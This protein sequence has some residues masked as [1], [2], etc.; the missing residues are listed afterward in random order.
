MTYCVEPFI[1]DLVWCWLDSHSDYTAVAGEVGIGSGVNSGRIDLV[2]KTTEGEFHGF[3]I[4]NNA[5][6]DEQLN[7]YLQSGYLDRLYHCSRVGTTFA[8]R[9]HDG[10]KVKNTTYNNQQIR[11][12]I[13][14]GIAVGQYTEEEYKQALRETF[15]EEILDQQAGIASQVN[16]RVLDESEKTVWARLTRNIGIPTADFDPSETYISLEKAM[17]MMWNNQAVPTEIGLIDVPFSYDLSEEDDGFRRQLNESVEVMF[18]KEKQ[19]KVEVV[20]QAE[21]LHREQSLTLSQ[22]NEAWVQHYAWISH[23]TIREAV[24]PYVAD[25]AE[26]LIDIMGFEGA[27][28]PTE[29]Y[30]AGE[31]AQLLGIEAKGDAAFGGKE[32]IESIREQL[33]KYQTSGVLTHLYLAVPKKNREEGEVVLDVP[34]LSEVGLLTVSRNGGVETEMTAERMSMQYDGYIKESGSHEYPRSVG[35]GNVAPNDELDFVQPCRIQG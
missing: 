5:F 15:P 7:R 10:Q 21:Q 11:K 12:E 30:R 25:D 9:L 17:K 4:K 14:N 23:G 3:E 2:A 8:E 31:D 26:Y 18:A 24:I 32:Q 13:S 1:Q 28:T 27:N 16:Q 20:R 29:V 34:R 6:A 19:D 35:F 22:T 33:C